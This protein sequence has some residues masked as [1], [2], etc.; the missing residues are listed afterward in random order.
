MEWKI[1][2][3][4]ISKIFDMNIFDLAGSIGEARRGEKAME[5][6]DGKEQDGDGTPGWWMIMMK[7]RIEDVDGTPGRWMIM[8]KIQKYTNANSDRI[9]KYK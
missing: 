6:R 3:I 2:D 4:S 5:G 9:H 8:M 1:F 7:S